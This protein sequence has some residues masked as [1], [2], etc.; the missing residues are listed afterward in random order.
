M[1]VLV[2]GVGGPAGINI[3]KCIKR[4][5]FI[6][7]IIGVDMNKYAGGSFLVDT[8]I[9]IPKAD[10]LNYLEE[11][12]K[13]IKIH[14]INIFFPTVDEELKIISES[15]S[16]FESIGV[17]IIINNPDCLNICLDKYA[18]YNLLKN[19]FIPIPET[20][21][22]NFSDEK[23]L[24]SF[25]IN[26][27]VILKPRSGRGSR[28]VFLCEDLDDLKFYLNKNNLDFI[29]QEYLP[30]QEYTVDILADSQYNPVFIVPRLRIEVKAG[31]SVKTKVILDQN[32]IELS[33]KICRICKIDS[34]ANLQFKCDKDNIPHLIE[35]N[36]RFGGGSIITLK[37]GI[38]FPKSAIEM[39]LGKFVRK[40]IELK[41]ITMVRIFQEYFTF[42]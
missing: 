20:I 23:D 36:P 18:T 10:D 41:E 7:N 40:P 2:S 29:I 12:L 11:I 26:Y 33:R 4:I 1:N 21:K 8:F 14:E 13:I 15:I 6:K 34:I 32:L 17:I 3:I 35:I 39:K 28:N 5:D 30:G 37:L 38:N 22:L 19:K 42:D 16:I 9:L 25:E 31:I 24:S 27:P